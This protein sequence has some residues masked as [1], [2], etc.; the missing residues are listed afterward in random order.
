MKS[1]LSS[2]YVETIEKQSMVNVPMIFCP[3]YGDD[4]VDDSIFFL[5]KEGL[6]IKMQRLLYSKKN[7]K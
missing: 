4:P 7:A 2:K 5:Q 3:K 6:T 1:F